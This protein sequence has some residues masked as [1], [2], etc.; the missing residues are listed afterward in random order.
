MKIK[1][2]IIALAAAAL[3]TACMDEFTPIFTVGEENNAIVLRAG[4]NESGVGA[5][6]RALNDEANHAKHTPFA[7]NT[8]I[9][10]RMDGLWTGH[11]PSTDIKKKTNAT[12]GGASGADNKHN[13]LTSFSPGFY[14]DDYG[15]A[16]P[17][18]IDIQNGGTATN[19]T[20][21]R[22][23][24]LDIFGAAI[25]GQTTLPT[26]L[27]SLSETQ[28]TWTGLPWSVNTNQKDNGIINSDLLTSN[29]VVYN[30]DSPKD[31]AYKFESRD[32]G[33]LL[34]FTHAMSKVT[35]VL[36]AGEG[37]PRTNAG[38]A[39]SAYFENEPNVTLKNFYN[40][41][42]VDVETK[43]STPTTSSTPDISM[44]RETPSSW[45]SSHTATYEA[46]VFPGNT[47][48]D[49][50]QILTFSVDGNSFNVTAKM[51]NA[52]IRKAID[53]H[54]TSGYPLGSSDLSAEPKVYDT[55][56]L[57]AWNY[58]LQITVNK[59]ALGI[60]ATIENWNEV[61]AAE[62]KPKIAI[63]QTYGHDGTAFD[64]NFDFF[65]S[66]TKA[67]GY[68]KDAWVEHTEPTTGTHK[69]TFHDQLYWPDHNTH[70]FFRGVY[71]RV[72]TA[73]ESGWIPAAKVSSSTSSA[74]TIAVQNVAYS[75]GTYPS[76]LAFGWPRTVDSNGN[77]NGDDETCKVHTSTP[78]QGICATEG[79]IRMNFNYVMSKVQFSLKSSGTVA[80]GNIVDLNNVTVEIINGNKSG[81]IRLSDG[82]HETFEQGD[83]DDYTLNKLDTPQDGFTVTTL[84]AIVPQTL[85]NDVKVRV[86]IKD[87]S[88]KSLDVY[89]AQ[90]NKI[91]VKTNDNSGTEIT[92]WKPGNYYKYELDINKT[93]ITV[94]ATLKDWVPVDASDNV[95][96]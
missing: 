61:E 89:D 67:D 96:F 33:K 59:T 14:W 94:T 39:T 29:N 80:E 31:N 23:R 64:K 12:L 13:E 19:G 32:N 10:L 48:A 2:K 27:L 52:A 5:K 93:A 76:D 6:T 66:T 8:V 83:K 20:G 56:L 73:S 63:T 62:D 35:V 87:G 81:K 85:G 50:D 68:S 72:Q 54:A 3:L 69:Y 49:D 24:G 55:H 77:E 90:L 9:A 75:Q 15:T 16:D 30:A 37:F 17:A 44:H 38:N 21:G 47:F 84:D 71:P 74:S 42:T 18:N 53:D 57:Q 86:T 4:V 91:K 11:S 43:T 46:V 88:G 92:E 51:L 79:N 22:E 70:Y 95:W 41:G 58:K 36:T 25:N 7:E 34:V 65:R 45:T 26:S 78:T 1:N 82:L 60:S 40:S 28:S